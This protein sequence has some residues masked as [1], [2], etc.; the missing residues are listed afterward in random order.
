MDG[1]RAR[2]RIGS[3]EEA[4]MEQFD[5][6]F[7]FYGLLL[8]LSAATVIIRFADAI[9][10]RGGRQIGLLAPLLGAFVLLDIASFWIWAWR[11]RAAFEV[12]FAYM[13]FGLAIAVPYFFST[14]QVFPKESADWKSLDAHYWARKRYV[15]PGI[16]VANLAV[17][18]HGILVRELSRAFLV[19]QAFY[20]IPLIALLFT[21]RKWMD[22]TLLV[23]LCL[24]YIV[25]SAILSPLIQFGS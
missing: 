21:R 4:R 14:S 16:I 15:I 10:E 8:G 17:M 25:G 13:Y 5:F 22:L 9:G 2:A 18:G 1:K 3:R 20:W 23:L 12:S 7:S 24:G 19:H 6:Y 11:A